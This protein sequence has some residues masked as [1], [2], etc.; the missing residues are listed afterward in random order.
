MRRSILLP[1]LALVGTLALGCDS[2]SGTADDAGSAGVGPNGG[3]LVDLDGQYQAEVVRDENAG[4]VAVFLLDADGKE[5]VTANVTDVTLRFI[6]GAEELERPLSA[7]PESADA[8]GTSRKFVASDPQVSEELA[9]SHD[10]VRL[11]AVVDGQFVAG[12][13]E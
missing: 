2:G 13:I 4:S 9:Q 3:R 5:P 10:W 7:E 1:A 11:E 8:D 6:D 12:S